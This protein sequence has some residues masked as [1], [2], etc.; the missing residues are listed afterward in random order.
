VPGDLFN[1]IITEILEP[2]SPGL[3]SL[4]WCFKMQIF[5]VFLLHLVV[6][7]LLQVLILEVEFLISPIMISLKLAVLK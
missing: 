5:W 7:E 6:S 3:Q 2:E 4:G 1:F